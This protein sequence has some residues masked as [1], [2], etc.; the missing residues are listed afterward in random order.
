METEAV[1]VVTMR[2]TEMMKEVVQM[3]QTGKEGQ[4]MGTDSEGTMFD[5][6]RIGMEVTAKGICL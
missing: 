6:N 3:V 2:M 4:M 1:A 5:D